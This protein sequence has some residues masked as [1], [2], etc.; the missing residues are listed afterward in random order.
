MTKTMPPRADLF[1]GATWTIQVSADPTGK[2]DHIVRAGGRPCNM[3]GQPRG[4][5][6]LA[7]KPNSR[8][9]ERQLARAYA[10]ALPVL[11][12]A[13]VAVHT[14]SYKRRP[15]SLITRTRPTS[16]IPCPVKPDASNVQKSVEDAL[17]RCRVCMGSKKSCKGRGH[18][19]TPT[20]TDDSSIVDE[21]CQTFYTAVLDVGAKLARP[22]RVV[23]TVT[24][25][26]P[27]TSPEGR[28]QQTLL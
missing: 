20:L 10:A 4:F 16:P 22:A 2:A 28:G 6:R 26:A 11:G 27:P 21:R 3:C 7:L 15:K 14:C 17:M 12:D 8:D 5:P 18:T 1:D 24:V 9:F 19:Y 25:V 13:M 23:V